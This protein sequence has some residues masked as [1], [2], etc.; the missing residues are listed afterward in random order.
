MS[1]ARGIV[2]D[3]KAYR[4]LLSKVL[5]RVIR[6]DEENE[7]YLAQLEALHER[8][9]LTP[10]EERIA[11][12]L[13]L[14]IEA[15]EEKTYKLRPA[16][17]IDVVRHLMESNGLKQSDLIDVFGSASVVSEVLKKKRQLSK[18]HIHKLS[19]RFHVSPEVF[20]PAV[21][22]EKSSINR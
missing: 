8:P 7:R 6:T 20:F 2:V 22:S 5:P 14:L 19:R 3:E 9:V 21:Q 16:S 17:P 13:T 10:E 18:A 12:L 11:E 4:K 15:Y 1:A